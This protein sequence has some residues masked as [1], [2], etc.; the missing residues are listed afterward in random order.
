MFRPQGAE[1]ASDLCVGFGIGLWRATTGLAR[2]ELDL[3]M[4]K[5][6]RLAGL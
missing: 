6:R 4:A 5:F 3:I 2:D 1:Q